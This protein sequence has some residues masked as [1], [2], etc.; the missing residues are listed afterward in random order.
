MISAHQTWFG[1]SI[2]RAPQQIRVDPV[3]GV[4]RAGAW[5]PID[6]L[7]PHQAHQSSGPAPPDAL[8]LAAQVKRHPTGAVKRVLQE[9]LV[10]PPHQQ[11]R[12]RALPLRRRSRARSARATA[13]G[14]AGSGSAPGDR[15]QPSRGA[16]A[17]SSTG[18]ARHKIPLPDQLPDLGVKIADLALMISD[19]GARCPSRTP[20]PDPSIAWRFHAHRPGSDG[21][22]AARRS[23]E[24]SGRPEAPPTPPSPSA[25]P[26]IDVACCSSAFLRQAVEYTLAT[27]PICRRPPHW[28]WALR[29][30]TLIAPGEALE[31]RMT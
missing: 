2:A 3:L 10:D 14:I 25:P 17:G 4:G 28:E 24:A 16:P 31:R 5:R 13:G 6:R 15:A 27:C 9:Q 12:F 19:A 26:K 29:K 18:P 23:P 30:W 22:D 20:R 8:A 7:Q 1:R 21:P 11:Q